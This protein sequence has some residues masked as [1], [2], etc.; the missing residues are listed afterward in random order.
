M[1]KEKNRIKF[2]IKA[3]LLGTIIPVVMGGWWYEFMELMEQK[4]NWDYDFTAVHCYDGGCDAEGF[5]KMI[6]DT[7]A[8]NKKPI[9]VT[10][11]GVAE[12]AGKQWGGGNAQAKQKV[13]A[14]MEKVVNGLE[15]RD[16]VERYAWF[17]FSPE[18]EYDGASGIFDYD[19]GKLTELGKL[20]QSLGVPEGYDP[21]KKGQDSDSSSGGAGPSGDSG[22]SID[23][24]TGS[25]GNSGSTGGSTGSSGNS[26]GSTNGGTGSSGNSGGSTNGGTGSS[27][28]SGNTNGGTDSS[29]NS[30][31]T[32]GSAGS[33]GST[34]DMEQLL[35][36]YLKYA[37]SLKQERYTKESWAEVSKAAREAKNNISKTQ[38]ELKQKVANLEKALALLQQA[39]RAGK[40]IHVEKITLAQSSIVMKKGERTVLQA[41]IEPLNA[42]DQ[43]LVWASSCINNRLLYK[44]LPVFTVRQVRKKA[45]RSQCHRHP[46]NLLTENYMACQGIRIL[47]YFIITRRYLKVTIG[48]YLL[49]MMTCWRLQTISMRKASYQLQWTAAT[50]GRWLFI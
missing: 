25:P 2:S 10:E 30:G 11:F 39:T 24:G 26:S 35:E 17:P 31:N 9:W 22:G 36:A 3:K 18:D 13:L 37:D 43:H 16:F 15:E 40:V 33:S 1:K 20:Y 34:T 49:P 45:L 44:P 8:M 12:W 29:G 41:A 7:Y 5:L 46:L 42:T 14:F 27:G 50:D 48:K 38:E 21:D 28:N 4:E 23:G 19:T 6:D 32:N 47:R